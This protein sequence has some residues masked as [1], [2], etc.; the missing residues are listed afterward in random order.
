MRSW[1]TL[2]VYVYYCMIVL[3]CII[4]RA[5]LVSQLLAVNAIKVT[6]KVHQISEGAV[7]L[8]KDFKR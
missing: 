7:L 8:L 4:H 3:V 6:V 2:C 1:Y 5:P